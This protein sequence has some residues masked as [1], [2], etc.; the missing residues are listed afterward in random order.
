MN[1]QNGYKVIY[2]KIADGER[3]FFADKLDG[4]TATQ[5]GET[6]KVGEYKLVFEKDGGIFGSV[7]GKVADGKRIEAFDK[8]FCCDHV[9]EDED[10][11]C[12]ICKEEM[13]VQTYTRRSRKAAPVVEDH[14]VEE[15]PVVEE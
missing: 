6:I 12:D 13:P 15:T 11:T 5:L 2:E 4:T 1:L 7:T 9:D 10:N 3:T 14:G 8:V